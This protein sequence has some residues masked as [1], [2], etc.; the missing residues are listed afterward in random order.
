MFVFLQLLLPLDAFDIDVAAVVI[1][2]IG[3]V[4]DCLILVLGTVDVVV[5]VGRVVGIRWYWEHLI[6]YWDL[7]LL[8]V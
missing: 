3:I 5:H 6:Y 2:C 1:L 8:L 7:L 4:F